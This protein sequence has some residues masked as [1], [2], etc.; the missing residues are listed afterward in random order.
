MSGI[1]KIETIFC[2]VLCSLLSSADALSDNKTAAIKTKIIFM[3]VRVC[4]WYF[5]LFYA[6]K[7]KDQC[8]ETVTIKLHFC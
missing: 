5:R 8:Y 2:V 1:D 6:T 4:N 7:M 3:F